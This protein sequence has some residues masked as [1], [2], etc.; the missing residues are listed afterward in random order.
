MSDKIF[1]DTNVL[2]YARDSSEPAKQ[3]QAASWMEFLWRTQRG[4]LSTQVLNEFYYT[5]TQKLK[6][7]MPADAAWEEV[8]DL[9]TWQPLS[10][11]AALLHETHTIQLRYGYAWWDSMIIAAAQRSKAR[12]LLSEDMQDGH[13]LRGLRIV[14]PFETSPTALNA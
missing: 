2:V 3:V 13:E 4:C 9:M 14:N 6:P 8:S 5:V 10:I 12:I 7:G 1:I 11:D